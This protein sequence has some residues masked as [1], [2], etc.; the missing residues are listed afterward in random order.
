MLQ[1]PEGLFPC[2]LGHEAAG[3]VCMYSIWMRMWIWMLKGSF[4]RY[5]CCC[6]CYL[7]WA[8]AFTGMDRGFRGLFIFVAGSW[9]V[10]E[11]VL[12]MLSLGIMSFPVTRLSVGSARLANQGRP[13]FA[14]R[15]AL[16]LE[17][18]SCSM[19]ARVGSRL[20][21]SPFIISWELPLLVNT[22][23]SMMLV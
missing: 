18:G 8:Y 21:E 3:Y 20:M 1:D 19:M 2:I 13:T 4:L 15:F 22:L 9:R 23:L 17:L 10:L 16:P 14:P 12:L 7:M 5:D 6:M 11:K